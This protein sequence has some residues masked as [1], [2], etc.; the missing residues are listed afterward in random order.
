MTLNYELKWSLARR[1]DQGKQMH[2]PMDL[3]L[4]TACPKIITCLSSDH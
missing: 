4:G 1:D 3:R 2:F